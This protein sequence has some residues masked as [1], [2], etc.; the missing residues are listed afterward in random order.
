MA[1][2]QEVVNLHQS[3]CKK[4]IIWFLDPFTLE[5]KVQRPT[6][7]KMSTW[8]YLLY[9]GD[10]LSKEVWV[11]QDWKPKLWLRG[12][13]ICFLQKLKKFDKILVVRL[14][15]RFWVGNQVGCSSF[16]WTLSLAFR[17]FTLWPPSR[18]AMRVHGHKFGLWA[19]QLK[20]SHCARRKAPILVFDWLFPAHFLGLSTKATSHTK[21]KACDHCNLRALI[22]RKGGNHPSSLHTQRWRPVGPKKTSWMKSRHG[23][24]EV[25]LT[26]IP[27]DHVFIFLNFL[28]QHDTFQDKFQDIQTPR[29]SFNNFPNTPGSTFGWESRVL[30]ITRSRLLAHVWSGPQQSLAIQFHGLSTWTAIYS[31][32]AALS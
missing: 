27:E 19:W 12:Y 32:K 6:L 2:C 20:A 4:P 7:I 9:E 15:G 31:V 8:K 30:T 29:N 17:G 18:E 13:R 24:Q 25:A 21:L 1:A 10:G 14:E 23:V 11:G 26:E 5:A 22:R 16:V 3:N 28:F